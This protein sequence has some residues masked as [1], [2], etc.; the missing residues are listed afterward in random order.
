MYVH[1]AFRAEPQAC[2]ALLLARGFGT[3]IAQTPEGPFAAHVPFLYRPAERR[4]ELHV[5]RANPMHAHVAADPRVLLTCTGPDAYVTPD[6]Y[7]SQNQ[8]ST[9]LYTA[10]HAT[11]HAAVMPADWLP[12]HLDRLSA[13]HEAALAPKKPWTSD[14]MDPKR[15]AAMTAAIVGIAIE[16]VTVTGQWKLNQHKAE[17]DHA[18]IAAA[19]RTRPEE[20]ARRIA[21]LM[22]G[23]RRTE[24][25]A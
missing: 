14:K 20:D 4:I 6:W 3:L 1:P 16:D 19:L 8:V 17:P 11:G 2:E 10:V 5:A 22:D 21:D 15:L 13:H 7:V 9:W 24:S 12:G 18:A 23:V 25:G